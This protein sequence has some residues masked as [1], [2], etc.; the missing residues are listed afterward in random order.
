MA[1]RAKSFFENAE[2]KNSAPGWGAAVRGI[3]FVVHHGNNFIA[4]P[5]E[6]LLLRKGVV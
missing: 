5:R 2:P 4:A 1:V 3:G 6:S